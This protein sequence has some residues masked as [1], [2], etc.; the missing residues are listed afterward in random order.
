MLPHWLTL[1]CIIHLFELFQSYTK[2]KICYF[3]KLHGC[4]RWHP[5]V[6]DPCVWAANMLPIRDEPA[7][8]SD[9]ADSQTAW[10]S[11]LATWKLQSWSCFS[12]QYVKVACWLYTLL[13]TSQLNLATSAPNQAA[14]PLWQRAWREA[15]AESPSGRRN[16]SK[17]PH[18][19]LSVLHLHRQ[20][21]PAAWS[22]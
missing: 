10:L 8:D 11:C 17:S 15:V 21:C 1:I 3:C 19:Q 22:V 18:T 6:M 20:N 12:T 2:P 14:A 13:C 4:W 9:Q 16:R 5:E 7:R